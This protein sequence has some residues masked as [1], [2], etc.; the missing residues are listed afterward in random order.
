MNNPVESLLPVWVWEVSRSACIKRPHYSINI[1]EVSW[2]NVGL[3]MQRRKEIA[4]HGRRGFFHL[5]VESVAREL[6]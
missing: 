4:G 2:S 6:R 1:G 3:T 5:N